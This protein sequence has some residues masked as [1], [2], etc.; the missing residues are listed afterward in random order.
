VELAH[1]EEALPRDRDV[2]GPTLGS[3]LFRMLKLPVIP[4]VMLVFNSAEITAPRLP[5]FAIACRSTSAA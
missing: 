1:R 3:P 5:A 2:I 4:S